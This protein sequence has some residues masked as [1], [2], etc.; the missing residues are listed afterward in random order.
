M[1]GSSV[2]LFGIKIIFFYIAFIAYYYSSY[3]FS[4]N[5][6]KVPPNKK[7]H[8]VLFYVTVFTLQLLAM[9]L[10]MNLTKLE[11]IF[12]KVGALILL[13]LFIQKM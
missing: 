10:I 13:V 7:L 5:T 4:K 6:A 11:R 8:L 12:I 9:M 2:I 3:Y 1:F